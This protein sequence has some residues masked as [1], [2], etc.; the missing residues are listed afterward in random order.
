[1]SF[2]DE[3][4]ASLHNSFRSIKKSTSQP[5][6]FKENNGAF[7]SILN[8][9][10]TYDEDYTPVE[11][12]E[13]FS[14]QNNILTETYP[15]SP[16]VKPSS[17]VYKQSETLAS[18]VAT[19]GAREIYIREPNNNFSIGSSTLVTPGS[20]DHYQVPILMSVTKSSRPSRRSH[21]SKSMRRKGDKGL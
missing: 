10:P 1:M 12:Q 18:S 15:N 4:P 9:M 19:H 16:Q 7:S 20:P 2:K 3:T 17:L 8:N 11:I 14:A 21:D 5:S 13:S 6:S